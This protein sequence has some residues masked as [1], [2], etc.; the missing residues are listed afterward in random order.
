MTQA[1]AQAA[2]AP[3]GPAKKAKLPRDQDPRNPNFRLA[4]LFDE[5]TLELITEDD[6][7]GMVAA[8]G[9]VDGTHV[10]AFCSDATVMGGAMGEVGCKVVVQAYER[11]LPDQA[12]LVGLG[13]SGGARLR[14]GA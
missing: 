6:G 7:S 5:G 8:V 1:P 14:A 12:P 11:A 10:V 4:A 13:H 3:K 2:A 9:R